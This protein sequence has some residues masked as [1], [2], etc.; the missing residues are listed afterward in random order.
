MKYFKD[1]KLFQ[2][3]PFSGIAID[4]TLDQTVNADAACQRREIIALT[5]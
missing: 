4:L 3:T 2:R 5:Y 1:M